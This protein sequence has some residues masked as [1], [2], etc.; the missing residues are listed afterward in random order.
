MI[1]SSL[2]MSRIDY[3]TS[4]LTPNQVPFSGHFGIW[5][6]GDFLCWILGQICT[7]ELQWK[8]ICS[9]LLLTVLHCIFYKLKIVILALFSMQSILHWIECSYY[10]FTLLSRIQQKTCKIEPK[11]CKLKCQKY[12]FQKY[13][14][15][16]T[17]A[18]CDNQF[19]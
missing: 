12:V 11:N 6:S 1:L 7:V 9:F 19:Y 16:H 5:N 8:Y 18:L 15:S 3:W 14:L 10:K 17:N 2:W 13:G 4:I